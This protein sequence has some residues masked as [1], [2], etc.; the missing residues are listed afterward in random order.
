MSP[1]IYQVYLSGQQT[2]CH[3]SAIFYALISSGYILPRMNV[4]GFSYIVKKNLFI[5]L[6]YLY[7]NWRYIPSLTFFQIKGAKHDH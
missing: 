7:F 1:P 2:T 4:K 3:S 5:L 6:G